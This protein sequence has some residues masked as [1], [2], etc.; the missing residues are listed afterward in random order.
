MWTL[1]R[2][3]SVCVKAGFWELQVSI[4]CCD[5]ECQGLVDFAHEQPSRGFL[6]GLAEE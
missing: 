4:N 1:V 5:C 6:N 3:V 2:V